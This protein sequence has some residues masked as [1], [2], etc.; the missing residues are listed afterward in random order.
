MS[1]P[2]AADAPW[3]REA[4]TG[5]TAAHSS[6]RIP[7]AILIQAAAGTGGDLLATWAAQL[8]LCT[9]GGACGECASCRRVSS[10]THPD[11]VMVSLAEDSQQIRIDQVR[12]LCADLALTSHQ[13]GYKV[14][15]ITPADALN[16]S[17]ANALLKTLEE[18]AP[19]TLVLLVAA[20]PSRLPA[21]LLSRCLRIRVRR[22]AR[23]E[24]LA[25]LERVRGPGDWNAVLD[26]IGEA[27]LSA[28]GA[29]PAAMAALSTE[30]GRTLDELLAG[31]A[32]PVATA[33]RWCR[34]EL[35]ARLDCLENW[36]T[37]RIRRQLG[38][39]AD[40]AEL[41]TMAHPPR[42]DRVFNNGSLFA[43]LDEARG[44][45]AALTGPI[46]RSLALEGLL[47]SL[48]GSGAP[49]GGRGTEEQGLK[50]S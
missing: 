23:S 43:S 11:L 30:V 26:V 13:G 35:A 4:M 38:V 27:P 6:G 19:R 1:G 31:T 49:R 44:L 16:R 21:T 7:H 29:D 33:E 9:R 34:A 5:L 15:I 37:E 24:S 2:V 50:H 12:E 8:V 40:T 46:N 17:A 18:P 41:R 36:L 3:L 22:P 48:A 47:R 45:K 42:A 10:G 25:W 20:Q 28:A 32:D 39:A 14:A